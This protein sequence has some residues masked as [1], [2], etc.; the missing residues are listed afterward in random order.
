MGREVRMVPSDW[1]HPLDV[2]GEYIPL[3][4]SYAYRY[5]PDKTFRMPPWPSSERTYYQM[6]EVS[7]KGTPISPP[8]QSLEDL[9]KW[10]SVND[11]HIFTHMTATCEQWME[12]CR[13]GYCTLVEILDI[14]HSF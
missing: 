13:R 14:I 11:A 10:L 12:V 7:S 1:V 2:Q 6:Y 9:V 8:M 4:D 5:D 3:R